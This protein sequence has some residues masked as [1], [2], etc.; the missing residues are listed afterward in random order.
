MAVYISE[1]N[2]NVIRKDSFNT[3]LTLTESGIQRTGSFSIKAV[4]D[5]FNQTDL[6]ILDLARTDANE[7]LPRIG[8][9]VLGAFVTDIQFSRMITK[10]RDTGND[11]YAWMLDYEVD[12]DID[13]NNFPREE[14]GTL[15]ATGNPGNPLFLPADFDVGSEIEYTPIDSADVER[16]ANGNAFVNR[17][18]ESLGSLVTNLESE[19][20]VNVVRI[21]RWGVWPTP[22]VQLNFYNGTVNA[23]PFHDVPIGCAWL[24]VKSKKAWYHGV[25]YARES[26]VIRVLIDPEDPTRQ[27]TWGEINIPEWSTSFFPVRTNPETGAVTI[28]TQRRTR[29]SLGSRGPWVLTADGTIAETE[30]ERNILTFAP[31][32]SVSWAPLNLPNR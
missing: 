7:R 23:E 13:L 30:A 19:R 27:N 16:D 4:A 2:G 28:G 22:I 24:N 1:I 20:A 8:E 17:F 21:Q 11:T 26:Y 14:D 32:R 15:D 29:D 10:H 6:Q 12:S 31:K 25:E 18:G 3:G 9:I 5:N